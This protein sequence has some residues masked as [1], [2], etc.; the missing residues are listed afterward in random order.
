MDEMTFFLRAAMKICGSLDE[1]R[2]LRECHLFL[3]QCP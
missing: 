1:N 3:K 2:M